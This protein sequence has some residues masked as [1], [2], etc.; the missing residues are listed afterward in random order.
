MRRLACVLIGVVCSAPART[1]AAEPRRPNVLI[2]IADDQSY[3]H[4]SAYGAAVRTP[5]FDRVAAAGVLFRNGFS[6]SPGCS[7]SRAALLTGRHHWELKEAGTHASSFPKELAVFPDLLEQ[8]GYFVGMTG[9][10]WGPGNWKASGR[11]RN[12]SGPSFDRKKLDAPE[13]VSRN[14][15]AANFEAFLDERPDGRPF[16]FWYGASEPHRPYKPGVGE[17]R[18]VDPAAVTVP[19]FLPDT[20]EVR[21]DLT[22]YF[23]EIEWFDSHLGRML[24]LLERRGELAGTLVIVTADNGMSFPRAKANC[25]DAGWHVPL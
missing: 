24:D 17:E 4:C 14:D 8:A 6:G 2:A 15:Y 7:P 10:G 9:K 1:E 12:P 13:G 19:P 23:A 22:D 21:R 20:P 16:C 11:D 5:A 18:G 3:P 25:Y